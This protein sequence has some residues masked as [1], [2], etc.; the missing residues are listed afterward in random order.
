MVVA[1]VNQETP[2]DDTICPSNWL[3]T[4]HHGGDDDHDDDDDD[5]DDDNAVLRG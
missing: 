4:C 2:P 1:E 3:Y 5:D